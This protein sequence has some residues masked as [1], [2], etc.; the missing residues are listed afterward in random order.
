M[1]GAHAVTRALNDASVRTVFSLSGNQVMPIYDACI[2][3]GIRIVH[4]RQE[5]AAVY[6]ADAWAQ[7]TSE[8][9]VALIAAGPAL[10]NGLSPLYSARAADSPVLLLSGDAPMSRDGQG[11]FQELAQTDVTR[12]IVKHAVRPAEVDALYAETMRAIN[13]ALS[14]RPGPV[15]VALPFDLM[16]Q[17]W[18]GE[19]APVSKPAPTSLDEAEARAI[20]D[21]VQAAQRPLILAG[22]GLRRHPAGRQLEETLGVPVI[23]MESPRGL[24]DPCLGVF[25]EV[26]AH[27]DLVVGMGK[28][29]DYTWNFGQSPAVAE[30]VEI[31][32]VDP[33][34]AQL[35]RAVQ[36]LGN[37]VSLAIRAEIIPAAQ[38]LSAVAETHGNGPWRET[39]AGAVQYRTRPDAVPGRLLSHE[40]CE[41][42][43]AVLSECRDPILVCDGGEFGQWAQAFCTAPTRI[44]NGVGGAIGGGLC[45]AIAAK[46]ARPESDVILMMGD[47][48]AGFHFAEFETAA[49][50]GVHIVAVIGNDFRWNAEHQLQLREYGENRLYGCQLSPEARYDVAAAGLGCIGDHVVDRTGLDQALRR[51]MNNDKPVCLNVEIEGPAAPVFTR[52]G[53]A[54]ARGH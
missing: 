39:V 44:I 13:A 26:L 5:A 14:G 23:G 11:A 34:Q 17:S 52:D 19:T 40:V 22:P 2:D 20:V 7:V 25:R 30:A 49:R 9:G 6:M 10:L 28:P 24:N 53:P 4:V 33:E 47:G 12:S 37:A 54:P 46:I 45:Y 8:P 29:V 38:A 43:Q 16:K 15:H 35:D 36:A 48:T 51:A 32:L 21:K 3:A 31:I 18:D 27:A 41:T 1:N 42:V 50:E